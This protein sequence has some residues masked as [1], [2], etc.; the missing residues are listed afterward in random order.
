[1]K[2][3]GE[4]LKALIEHYEKAV[5]ELPEDQLIMQ[6][7]LNIQCLGWGICF[8][9]THKF[10][11][12]IYRTDFSDYFTNRSTIYCDY[13]IYKSYP[14]AKELLQKRIDRM[15]EILPEWENVLIN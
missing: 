12:R 7:Y 6:E 11:I 1:M 3:C 14:N 2:T 13:P 8:A 4:L 15:K 5:I 9:S 10:S